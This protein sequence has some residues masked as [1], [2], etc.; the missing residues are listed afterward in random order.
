M[1]RIAIKMLMGDLSKYF[2]LVSSL[3]VVSFLFLQQG[4]IFCGSILRTSRPVEVVGA[5]IWVSDP[6][7]RSVD[8]RRQNTGGQATTS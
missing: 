4:S 2:T 3:I 8:E 1:W 6:Q 5:P 7:L